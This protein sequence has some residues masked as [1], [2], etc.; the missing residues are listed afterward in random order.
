M[1]KIINIKE[2]HLKNFMGMKKFSIY[3]G[4]T[5]DVYGE[6]ASGKTTIFNGFTWLLFEKDSRDRKDFS[7]KTYDKNGVVLPGLNHEVEAVLSVNEKELKLKKIYREKW[8]KKR[9]QAYKTLTGH[10]TEY[11]VNDLPV[12]KKE[13]TETINSLVQ[14]NIFKLITNPLYFNNV[15]TWKKRREILLTVVGDLSLSEVINSN[16]KLIGFSHLIGDKSLEDFQKTLAIRKKK[17]NEEIKSIPFR[18]D[19]LNTSIQHISQLNFVEIE[20]R[21]IMLS[22]EVETIDKKLAQLTKD[23]L[24]IDKNMEA[25]YSKK[26]RLREIKAQYLQQSREPKLQLQQ[27]IFNI[28]QQILEI[29]FGIKMK[30][31]NLQSIKAERSNLTL[32]IQGL[33]EEWFN[34]E[35]E[36]LQFKEDDFTCPTCGR[37]FP[38]IV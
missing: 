6:N 7:I 14:E 8:T 2:L 38:K 15:L 11:T 3:F 19:E 31:Q 10:I 27:N 12:Q 34:L 25:L 22:R 30:T 13:Y 33:R 21:K 9:G 23:Y 1:N 24:E 28:E 17:L 26:D 37:E 4:K 29:N 32:K 18:L 20:K 16:K 5:T 35:K 36:T